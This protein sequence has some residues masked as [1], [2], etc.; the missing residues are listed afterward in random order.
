MF[1]RKSDKNRF[2]RISMPVSLSKVRFHVQ[3]SATVKR[4]SDLL[5]S[6]LNHEMIAQRVL[7]FERADYYNILT[8]VYFI[9]SLYCTDCY[10][11]V[12]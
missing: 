1:A 6:L 3:Y 8:T 10:L 4:G 11:R 7:C 2:P 12:K 5:S 9:F